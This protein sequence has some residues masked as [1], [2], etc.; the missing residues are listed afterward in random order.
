MKKRSKRLLDEEREDRLVA[1]AVAAAPPLTMEQ[2][3]TLRT[4][5]APTIRALRAEA[6]AAA[7]QAGSM[8]DRRGQGERLRLDVRRRC[9]P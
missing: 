9:E 7:Q 8:D 6:E 2:I 1:I 4:L 3:D 5:F